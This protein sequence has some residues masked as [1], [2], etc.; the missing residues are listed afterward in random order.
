MCP[1]HPRR[2]DTRALLT[3]THTTLGVEPRERGITHTHTPPSSPTGAPYII[4]AYPHTHIP[5]LIGTGMGCST[6]ICTSSLSSGG[7][8]QTFSH[9]HTHSHW[10][11]DSPRVRSKRTYVPFIPGGGS[12]I[13]SF[14]SAQSLEREALHTVP[15]LPSGGAMNPFPHPEIHPGVRAHDENNQQKY[16]FP[17]P[18][19]ARNH[20]RVFTHLLDLQQRNGGVPHIHTSPRPPAYRV[21]TFSHI[22]AHTQTLACIHEKGAFTTRVRPLLPNATRRYHHQHQPPI[23]IP[24]HPTPTPPQQKQQHRKYHQQQQR[25]HYHTS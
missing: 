8:P 24:Q 7:E 2:G 4:F 3:S 13:H 5:R 14:T 18:P 15:F 23:T 21:T 16:V 22:L 9:I 25:Q 10:Y 1:I 11:A 20:G 12:N 6:E 17:L 19:R